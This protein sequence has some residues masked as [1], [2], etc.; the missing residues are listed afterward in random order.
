MGF[1]DLPVAIGVSVRLGSG[2]SLYI[3]S[4]IVFIIII[5]YLA[6]SSVK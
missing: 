4:C 6:W 2:T 1:P 3:G 5:V